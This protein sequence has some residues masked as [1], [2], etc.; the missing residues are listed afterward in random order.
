MVDSKLTSSFLSTV[1]SC[2]TRK[3]EDDA[4]VLILIGQ[5]TRGAAPNKKI[6]AARQNKHKHCVTAH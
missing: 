4:V 3:D 5:K 6:A 1:R 2:P